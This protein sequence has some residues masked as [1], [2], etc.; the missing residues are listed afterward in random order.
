MKCTFRVV[1]ILASVVPISV[2]LTSTAIAQ[3]ILIMQNTQQFPAEVRSVDVGVY[4]NGDAVQLYEFKPDHGIIGLSVRKVAS[5]GSL[6]WDHPGVEMGQHWLKNSRLESLP[7]G[8]CVIAWSSDH[9]PYPEDEWHLNV[10]RLNGDGELSWTW[11][12]EPY[13]EAQPRWVRDL[14]ILGEDT[15]A[16]GG[17]C[18]LQNETETGF[19][20]KLS[21]ETGHEL[22]RAI[23]NADYSV[24]GRSCVM[25]TPTRIFFG[26]RSNESGNNVIDCY[27]H[28]GERVWVYETHPRGVVSMCA[29]LDGRIYAS[30]THSTS[31]WYSVFAIDP[32]GQLHWYREYNQPWGASDNEYGVISRWRDQ[33][34]LIRFAQGFL[35]LL[36]GQGIRVVEGRLFRHDNAYYEQHPVEYYSNHDPVF[37]Y[38][39]NGYRN[40]ELS[41]ARYQ[42]PVNWYTEVE[43]SV[44]VDRVTSFEILPAYPNPFNTSTTFQLQMPHSGDV[45]I[46]I[47][48]VL[49]RQVDGWN[50]SA[51]GAGVVPVSW[52]PNGLSS[53]VYFLN[54]TV[55]SGEHRVRKLVHVQ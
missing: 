11:E 19:I 23:M 29:G 1:Q 7:D 43:E 20:L 24:Y 9:E 30:G 54:A 51:A 18:E 17:Y 41:I 34:T 50:V 28:H 35:V 45:G 46:T 49:G 53:G 14:T 27:T 55:P 47:T 52:S 40:H 10:V 3:P 16:V 37:G 5:D 32:G 33:S 39:E 4:E 36:N 31:N 48:D 8:G 15:V 6:L 44:A 25:I 38:S 22:S 2:C 13:W 26:V 42:P 21:L 12:S